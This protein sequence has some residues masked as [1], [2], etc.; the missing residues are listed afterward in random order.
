MEIPLLSCVYVCSNLV[1]PK[2]VQTLG[3]YQGCP[4]HEAGSCNAVRRG[5]FDR[6][7]RWRGGCGENLWDLNGRFRDLGIGERALRVAA[8]HEIGEPMQCLFGGI[9]VV[10][11]QRSTVTRLERIEKRSRFCSA[12]FAE[13]NSVQTPA[14]GGPQEIVERDANLEGIGLA[15]HSQ[16][17]GLLNAKLSRILDNYDPCL[18]RNR[19]RQ[20]IA[21]SGLPGSSSATGKDGFAHSNLI[22]QEF[23]K[24]RTQCAASDEIIDR[25]LPAGKLPDRERWV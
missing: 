22:T 2:L 9:R 8:H 5:R 3:L 19:L 14:Q 11:S 20:R 21:Q 13:D 17:V 7:S 6:A 24:R 15:S 10:R 25:E 1:I 18:V 4:V 23:G 12:D 16:N